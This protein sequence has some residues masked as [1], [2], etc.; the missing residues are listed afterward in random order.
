M[1][2]LEPVDVQ[3]LGIPQDVQIEV[4]DCRGQVLHGLESLVEI[5]GRLQA[6]H[7]RWRKRPAG[8]VMPCKAA[9]HLGLQQPVLVKLRRQLH[10]IAL[11]AGAGERGIG[12]IG[13]QAV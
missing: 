10:E 2:V 11:H 5:A 13:Q 8:L 9:Q 1:R 6:F 3:S 7:E 12:D 4:D